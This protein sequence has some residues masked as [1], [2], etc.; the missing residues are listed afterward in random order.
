MLKDALES[1]TVN[2]LNVWIDCWYR[3]SRTAWNKLEGHSVERR[4]H[5]ST[6]AQWSFLITNKRRVTSVVGYES[7]HP[8]PTNRSTVTSSDKHN[9]R[10]PK[11]EGQRSLDPFDSTT[12]YTI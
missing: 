7:P 8:P 1:T 12:G 9:S 2:T 6:K 11:S 10:V 3:K 5:T 4:A